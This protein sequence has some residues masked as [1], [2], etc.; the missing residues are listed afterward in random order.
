MSHIVHDCP[1]NKFEAGLAAIHIVSDSTTEWL[2]HGY[3]SGTGR[4]NC[5]NFHVS[6]DRLSGI[7]R[8]EP[9]RVMLSK[10]ARKRLRKL[11][12][13][14]ELINSLQSDSRDSLRRLIHERRSLPTYM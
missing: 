11:R 3:S 12:S 5:A 6:V 1:V 14:D 8:Y 10:F 9:E 7:E 4:Q 13:T 2:R